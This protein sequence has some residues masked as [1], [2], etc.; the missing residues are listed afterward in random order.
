MSTPGPLNGLR[1]LEVGHILAG[2]FAGMLLA[3]MGADVIKVESTEG[4]LSRQVGSQYIGEHNVYFAS[5]NRGKRSVHIDLA[6]PEGQMQLGE[7]AATADALIVNMRPSAI[8]KL[9]LDYAALRRFNPK[10][11][12]VAVT[13]YGLDGPAAERPAFDY[14]IQAD[15]GIAAMCGEPD[16][17]PTLAGYS[18]VDNSSSIMAALALL[19]KV[20]EGKGGQVDVSLFDVMLSQLNYKA[21]A[22][23]NGGVVPPRHHLGAHSFYVPAQLFETADGYLALFVTHDEFWRR[24]CA[25]IGMPEWA[26]DPRFSTMHARFD[27]RVELIAGLTARLKEATALE[28]EQRFRPL[29]IPAGAA[30]TLEEVLDGEFLKTRDLVVSLQT[31]AG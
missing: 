22:Y 15:T 26:S 14:I 30:V 21:A 11:V 1:I 31:D 9:G 3:D 6:S 16:A 24:L 27:N 28:W 13:G 23:L 17:A 7:L 29:G 18:I 25:E 12:S 2:P 20:H 5:I 19:A 4:D 10:I 8:R